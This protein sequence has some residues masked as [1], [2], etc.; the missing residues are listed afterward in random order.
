MVVGELIQQ[1]MHMF[2]ADVSARRFNQTWFSAITLLFDPSSNVFRFYR[3]PEKELQSMRTSKQ[4]WRNDIKA[5]DMLDVFVKAD[6]RSRLHGW[7]QGKVA[8]VIADSLFVE[9]PDSL[10]SYDT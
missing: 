6:E 3:I 8:S 7:I 1:L 4:E 10:K 2:A 5:D 9:F